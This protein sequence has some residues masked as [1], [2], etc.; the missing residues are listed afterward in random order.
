MTNILDFKME[1][2]DAEA[3][4]IREYMKELFTEEEYEIYKKERM[5]WIQEI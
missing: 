5:I 3:T 2:N 1:E 4:T